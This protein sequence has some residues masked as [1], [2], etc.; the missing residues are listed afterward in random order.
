LAAI[1]EA[2]GDLPRARR[3]LVEL[4]KFDHTNVAAARRLAALA[5]KANATAEET[6]ALRMVADLDPFDA[7][8]HG[9]LGRRLL[10]QGNHA[11]A[12]VE[13]QAALALGPVNRAEAYTDFAEALFKL[14]RKEEAR[15]HVLQALKEAPTF[16]RAQDL[17]LS[18]SGR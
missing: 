18:I 8:T 16:A 14:G 7:D 5:G 1:T 10:A 12:A 6:A 17:Y 9:R 4:L 3:E 15:T 2:A 13:F 11:A